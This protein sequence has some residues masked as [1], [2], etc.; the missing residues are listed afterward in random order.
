MERGPARAR[1]RRCGSGDAAP[2]ALA[3]ARRGAAASR[4]PGAELPRGMS[5]KAG[6]IATAA[7]GGEGLR[8]RRDETR[9]PET[10]R[11]VRP[12]RGERCRDAPHIPHPNPARPA[13]PRPARPFPASFSI[14]FTSRPRPH[15][16]K[17]ARD[18]LPSPQAPRRLS[19]HTYSC[20]DYW[21]RLRSPPPPLPPDHTTPL[22]PAGS[23]T[24]LNSVP[25]CPE[26][27]KH[28][29]RGRQKHCPAAGPRRA[30]GPARERRGRR[31]RRGGQAGGGQQRVDPAL[32][33][34]RRRRVGRGRVGHVDDDVQ[35]HAAGEQAAARAADG[36]RYAP[37]VGPGEARCDGHLLLEGLLEGGVEVGEGHREGEGE[38][39]LPSSA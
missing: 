10:I 8:G 14:F 18:P 6:V 1:G 9:R 33:E 20:A 32:A 38:L 25:H 34:R 29:A 7:A 17:P 5:L 31:D 2:A 22:R 39:D 11:R 30:G 12:A 23:S 35:R 13:P 28:G 27:A 24:D 36:E 15:P 21:R 16:H 4:L 19:H 26:Q 37:A 3:I